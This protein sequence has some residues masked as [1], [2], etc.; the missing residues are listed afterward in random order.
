MFMKVKRLTD[1]AII[2]TRAHD[3]DAGVDVYCIQ[4][5]VVYPRSDRVLRTGIAISIPDGWVAIVKEKSGL[6]TTK[7]VTVGACVID[8]GYRGEIMIHLF[9]N[10]DIPATFIMGSKIAQ[11]V[12]VPCWIGQPE[13]VTQ[14]DETTRGEGRFGSTDV[15]TRFV[16]PTKG[17]GI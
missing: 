16:K 14:L 17:G 3:T 10:T 6:A 15:G 5:E 9:N 11:L 8:S 7:K 4:N 13:E 2:P 12:V 1:N